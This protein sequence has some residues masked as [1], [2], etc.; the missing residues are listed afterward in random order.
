MRGAPD[1]VGS[2][3]VRS[4][5]TDE[6]AVGQEYPAGRPPGAGAAIGAMT[7]AAAVSDP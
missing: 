3:V 5:E 1:R 2:G 6:G 4:G 7:A